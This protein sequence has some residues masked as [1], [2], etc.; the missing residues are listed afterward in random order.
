MAG[1]QRPSASRLTRAVFVSG[2]DSTLARQGMRALVARR[3][4]NAGQSR[5]H[6]CGMSRIDYC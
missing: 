2:T 6:L 3:K 4:N 5:R 1:C